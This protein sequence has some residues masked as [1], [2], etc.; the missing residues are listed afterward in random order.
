MINRDELLQLLCKTCPGFRDKVV[1]HADLWISDDGEF[2][3]HPWMNQ[4]CNLIEGRLTEGDYSNTD[5]LFALVERLLR[6]GDENVKTAV[7]TGFLEGLQHQSRLDSKFWTH[8]LGPLASAHCNA[9]NRFYGIEE[10]KSN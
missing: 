10:V 9:M 5:E 3:L 8:L 7:A 2:L 4:L 6:D 1:E